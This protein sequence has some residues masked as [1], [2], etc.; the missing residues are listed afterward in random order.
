LNC[1]GNLKNQCLSCDQNSDNYIFRNGYCL[2]ICPPGE[3]YMQ[4]LKVCQNVKQCILDVSIDNPTIYPIGSDPLIVNLSIIF[5]D[6]CKDN[7]AS[8]LSGLKVSWEDTFGGTISINSFSLTVNPT[9]FFPGTK[10][11]SANLNH[12][13]TFVYKVSKS[14]LFKISNVSLF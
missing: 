7:S 14:T 13:G 9:N 4:S 5:L 2:N 8:I 10:I 3:I 12:L 1:S 6:T 11:I